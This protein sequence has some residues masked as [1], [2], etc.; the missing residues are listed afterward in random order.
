MGG[1]CSTILHFINDSLFSSNEGC[2][3]PGHTHYGRY[4]IKADSL[5]LEHGLNDPSLRIVKMD[6]LRRKGSNQ[7][8]LRF[9]DQNGENISK[10]F[11]AHYFRSNDRRYGFQYDSLN[12]VLVATNLEVQRVSVQSLK[13][14]GLEADLLTDFTSGIEVTYYLQIPPLLY[15]YLNKDIAG[16]GHEVLLIKPDQLIPVNDDI[17][18][19]SEEPRVF[20]KD[21][22]YGKQ[23]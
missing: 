17:K 11:R 6:S 18:Y 19:V 1:L 22:I 9:I 23:N 5:F 16:T 21:T 10:P 4:K 15:R 2:E 8:I 7:I 20:R 3:G 14:M 13:L 12:Q